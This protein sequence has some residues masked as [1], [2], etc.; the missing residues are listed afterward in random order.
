MEFVRNLKRE[1]TKAAL[2]DAGLL[3]IRLMLA[4][5]FIFHGGQKLFGWWDGYGFAGTVDLFEQMGLPWPAL[6]AVLAGGAEF[7]GA[8]VLIIGHGTRLAAV[9]LIF[10]ML[11]GAV[12]AHDGFAAATGGGEYAYTLAAVL[13]GLLLTG[14]GRFTLGRLA[15]ALPRR[16]PAAQPEP[17]LS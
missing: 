7:F 3:V 15:G 5:V 14:P 12:V 11:V 4:V 13:L 2:S 9:P 6:S 1:S 10:T 16:S 17:T 8:L